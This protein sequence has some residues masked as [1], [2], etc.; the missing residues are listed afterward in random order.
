MAY[1]SRLTNQRFRNDNKT[2]FRMRERERKTHSEIGFR[3]VNT[4]HTQGL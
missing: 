2:D 3:V 1:D 4:H